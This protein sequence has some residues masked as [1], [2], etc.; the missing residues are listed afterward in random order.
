[1]IIYRDELFIDMKIITEEQKKKLFIPRKLSTNDSRYNEW[2]NEQPEIN[3]IKI[4]Q[5]TYDGKKI[6]VWTESKCGDSYAKYIMFYNNDG[7]K[8]G[9]YLSYDRKGNIEAKGQYINDKMEGEWIDYHSN[10]NI[11][12]TGKY[13]NGRMYGEWIA[14]KEDGSILFTNKY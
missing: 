5:Y 10:G 9:E 1:M 8:D 2:N 3:G 13:S 11:R 7:L 4:N 6:G 14:Y 12:T